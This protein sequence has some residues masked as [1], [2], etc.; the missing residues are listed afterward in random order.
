VGIKVSFTGKKDD[1]QLVQ[2]LSG[3]QK[4]VVAL[5]LIFAIQVYMCMAGIFFLLAFAAN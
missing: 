5:A 1:V 2:Q 3:G 4:S